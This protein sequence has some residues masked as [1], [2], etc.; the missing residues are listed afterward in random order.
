MT[1]NKFRNRKASG[2]AS[3]IQI[4]PNNTS[5][6][7]LL[8]PIIRQPIYEENMSP[9]QSVIKWKQ[10]DQNGDEFGTKS[11]VKAMSQAHGTATT[12]KISEK[13]SLQ[14]RP[15]PRKVSAFIKIS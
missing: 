9:E 15:T 5:T 2:A 14:N 6:S 8:S 11:M 1:E 7:G 10:V 13:K 4:R 12:L 3:K